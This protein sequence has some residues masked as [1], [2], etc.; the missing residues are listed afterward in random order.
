MCFACQ[1]L[2]SASS[3]R[4]VFRPRSMGP[5]DGPKV[6]FPPSFPNAG[7]LKDICRFSKAP[8]RYQKDMLPSTGFGYAVRQAEAVNQLQ[9]WYSVCCAING[10]QEEKICCSE[11]AV[12]VSTLLYLLM[13][14]ETV[15]KGTETIRG[16]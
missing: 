16:I 3:G 2:S 8:V 11:Q 15:N 1:N 14:A 7:N 13:F 10:S 6:D 4:Q 5:L 9:S 12:R